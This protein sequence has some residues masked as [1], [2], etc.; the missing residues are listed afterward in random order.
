MSLFLERVAL[1]IGRAVNF[2]LAGL[3]L[4]GLAAAHRRH[5]VAAD[6]E[7]GARGDLFHQ[8][9][10]KFGKVAD[11]LDIVDGR[12]IVQGDEGHVLV[13]PFGADPALH[14]NIVLGLSAQ[15][16]LDSFHSYS[17]TI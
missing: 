2:D 3:D 15:I 8:G 10:V 4:H 9:L 14:Y 7:A 13:S 5:K 16:I 6:A 1:R 17:V 11:D 12:S